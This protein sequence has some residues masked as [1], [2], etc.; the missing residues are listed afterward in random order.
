MTPYFLGREISIEFKVK[1]NVDYVLIPS[2]FNPGE[3]NPFQF[4]VY[5]QSSKCDVIELKRAI[6]AEVPMHSTSL[7]DDHHVPV[8]SDVHPTI[9]VSVNSAWIIGKTAGGC[10]NEP[11]WKVSPQ[12][13]LEIPVDEKVTITLKQQKPPDGK[14]FHIGFIVMKSE[15]IKKRK[16]QTSD[17]IHQT[18]FINTASTSGDINLKAGAYNI[19]ACTFRPNIENTFELSVY[20]QNEKVILYELTSE[21]DWKKVSLNGRWSPGKDGGCSNNK[22]TW[23]NNPYYLLEL[24]QKSTVKV[25]VDVLILK[26]AIGYYLWTTDDG[27]KVVKMIGAS[28]F[29]QGLKNVSV[30]KDWE[31]DPGKYIVIPT[32]FEPNLHSD[33]VI[34]AYSEYGCRLHDN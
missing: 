8:T 23:M 9:S 1:E 17:V 6:A 10:S 29:V 25:V 27:K 32:T 24:H 18:Q 30:S 3:E 11:T 21:N 13:I 34:T 5:T 4:I 2:H 14:Y 31:L 19:V 22:N 33:F 15:P 7:I 20:G 28:T 16:F 26:S 12:F